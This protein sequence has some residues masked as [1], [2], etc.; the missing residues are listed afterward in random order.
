VAVQAALVEAAQ[1]PEVLDAPAP[2][3]L[4]LE[5]EGDL[6][7]Y[8]LEFWIAQPAR[9]PYV[10]SDVRRRIWELFA[11]RGIA[12]SAPQDVVLVRAGE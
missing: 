3:A 11:A 5:L 8:D 12:M 6:I 2:V 1:H 7:R 9:A 10:T 4:L